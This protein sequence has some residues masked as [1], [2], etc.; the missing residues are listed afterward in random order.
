MPLDLAL[1]R[2]LL[3]VPDQERA[4]AAYTRLLGTD[5]GLEPRV[6]NGGVQ[7][8][9]PTWAPR[10]GLM[11]SAQDYDAAVRL[12]A[13]R[14]LPLEEKAPASDGRREAAAVVSGLLL[15]V[16]EGR[17][18]EGSPAQAAQ[19]GVGAVDHVVVSTTHL[20]RI[21]ATLGGRLGLDLRLEQRIAPLI[22][23][24]FFRCQNTVVEV[25]AKPG[26]PGKGDSIWGIAWRVGDVEAARARL[27]AGGAEVSEVRAG[28]K[29]GTRV[30][31]V[32][33]PDLAAPTLLIEHQV[34]P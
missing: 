14:G 30:V 1:D 2:V 4:R 29:R 13:R 7:L 18:V 26:L 24:L 23:Q 16:V 19:G 31:T 9:L 10:Q 5:A 21:V 8:G 32:K 17:V 6:S 33:D 12:L 25:L 34:K 22:N 28:M 3:D 20:D 15:G 27:V 11:F